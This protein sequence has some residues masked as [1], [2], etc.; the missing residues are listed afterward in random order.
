MLLVCDNHFFEIDDLVDAIWRLCDG[1][2]TLMTIAECLAIERQMPLGDAVAAT[3]ASA[4]ML[5]E[6]GLLI[7]PDPVET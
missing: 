5:R 1:R 4:L 3:L 2:S 7:L 6:A